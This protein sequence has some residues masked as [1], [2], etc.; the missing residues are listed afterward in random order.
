MRTI[1]IEG[2]S[3]FECHRVGLSTMELFMS[4]GWD[5]NKHMPPYDPGSL[6]EDLREL[7]DAW[8]RGPENVP[9]AEWII[10]PA[11][12]RGRKVVGD[13]YPYKAPFNRP[14]KNKGRKAD[15]QRKASGTKKAESS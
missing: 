10:P 5:P 15:N 4:N 14:Q 2:N 9:G 13:D 8:E 1:H 12:G 3:C 7:L 11:R 6:A